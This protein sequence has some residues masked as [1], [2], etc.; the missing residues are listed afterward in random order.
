VLSL[1]NADVSGRKFPGIDFHYSAVS[2]HRDLVP[3]APVLIEGSL[4]CGGYRWG[5]TS[6]KA[7]A[8]IEESTPEGMNI[9][10]GAS[11]CLSPDPQVSRRIAF[12]TS[13]VTEARQRRRGTLTV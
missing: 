8:G 11:F 9:G 3:S 13:C 1:P 7:R 6:R 10:T 5:D 2:Q 12:S 4:N